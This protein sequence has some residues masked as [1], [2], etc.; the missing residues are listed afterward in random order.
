[1][2]LLRFGSLTGSRSLTIL[3]IQFALQNTIT[4]TPTRGIVAKQINS[5]FELRLQHDLAK[6][7][8]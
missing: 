8:S 1:M 3:N 2:E 6:Q 4:L 7:T 5:Q